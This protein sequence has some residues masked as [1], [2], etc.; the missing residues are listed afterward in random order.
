M[1]KK[2]RISKKAG[3]AP[4]GPKIE[5]SLLPEIQSENS[6][7]PG[8]SL[9]HHPS[10]GIVL[11]ALGHWRYGEMA[12][13][14]AASI[15]VNGYAGPICLIYQEAAI[16]TLLSKHK[17]LFTDF[18]LMT[19]SKVNNGDYFYAKTLL[20]KL[21]PYDITLYLDADTLIMPGNDLTKY[22]NQFE[23]GLEFKNSGSKKLKDFKEGMDGW[24]DVSQ[25]AKAYN[26]PEET[27]FYNIHS[28]WILFDK[29][30]SVIKMFETTKEVYEKPKVDMRTFG[31]NIADE[32]AFAIAMAVTG[33]YPSRSPHHIGHW[34]TMN[35]YIKDR[36]ELYGRVFLSMGG[37][38]NP[39]W[40]IERYDELSKH[41]SNK[42]GIGIFFQYKSKSLY[43]KERKVI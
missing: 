25:V 33:C 31:N 39:K 32:A 22:F 16:S 36:S 23:G 8:P 11:I 17:E 29:S 41:Y 34:P 7:A 5:E 9:L 3:I 35:G 20:N 14:L 43:L 24:L 2:S 30:E 42:L 21:S 13:T 26:L 4:L 1:E 28:E 27:P 12:A 18:R 37:A 38:N 15:R 6:V 19:D 10:K 40:S